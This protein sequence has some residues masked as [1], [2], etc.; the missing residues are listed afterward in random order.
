M[1]NKFMGKNTAHK[2]YQQDNLKLSFCVLVKP[3]HVAIILLTNYD[4][5][6]SMQH[7]PRTV[8]NLQV[9]DIVFGHFCR[10]LSLLAIKTI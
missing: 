1:Y 8:L 2:K 10:L 5:T 7:R 9:V 3:Q 4:V 6:L